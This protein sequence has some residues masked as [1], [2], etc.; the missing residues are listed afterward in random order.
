MILKWIEKKNLRRDN[1]NTLYILPFVI[2]YIVIYID[3]IR[4]F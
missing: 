1:N 3:I 2:N 4:R